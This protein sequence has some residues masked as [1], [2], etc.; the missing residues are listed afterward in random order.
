MTHPAQRFR[1]PSSIQRGTPLKSLFDDHA[2][3]LIGE[4]FAAVHAPFDARSFRKAALRGLDDLELMPRAAH[5]ARSLSAHLP[6]A[7]QALSQVVI[8][9]LGPPLQGTA[10]MGLA[11]F[12]YMPHAALIST[13]LIEDYLAGMNANKAITRRFT[14]EFSIR[15]YIIRYQDRCLADL[16]FWAGDGDPHVRRLVSEGSRPRLPWAGR[17]PA[18]QRDP[19]L[20]L[21][22]L[23]RLKDDPELYVRRSV[24]N[25]LGDIAKDHPATA[26]AVCRRWLDEIAGAPKPL[27]AQRRW[28]IRHAVRLPAK[29]G[30][31]EAVRLRR[32]AAA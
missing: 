31:A 15:P 16:A 25:H 19:S 8:A 29:Q 3:D 7:P 30:V 27:A 21:G 12:F 4:S 1:A 23:E 28:M 17:L 2:I 32:S 18:I 6:A 26:F 24:A 13:A 10:G 9:A 5:I 20:T 11:P 14:A 22:L